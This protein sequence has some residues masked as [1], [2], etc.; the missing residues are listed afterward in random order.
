MKGFPENCIATFE[1]TLSKTHAILEIDPHYTKDS[2]IVLMH[3]PTLNRT[4]NGQ[5]KISDYTLAELKKLK[6]KDTEGNLT[7]YSMPTLD[8]ALQWAKGKTL[9][10]LDQKDVP[11]KVRVQK[12]VENHAENAAIIM[13]YNFADAK[14]GYS[15]NKNI[16][17]EVMFNTVEKVKEFDAT[18]VPWK[19][20]VVFVSHSLPIKREVFDEIHKRGAMCMIGTSRNFDRDFTTGK[21]DQKVLFENYDQVLAAGADIIEADL[22]IEA[23]TALKKYQNPKSSKFKFF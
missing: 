5:G 22:G 14:I 6:L 9:L 15:L 18:G 8:E 17:M 3:D 4:S 21:S 11:M 10:V 23:G 20:V 7:Q 19:N 2:M 1:N 12:V 16:V 13:A